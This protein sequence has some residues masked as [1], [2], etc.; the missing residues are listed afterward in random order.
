MFY[1]GRAIPEWRGSL[2]IAALRGSHVIR[3]VIQNNKVVGEERLFADLH[4]RFRHVVQG[5]DQAIY[6]IIDDKDGKIFRISK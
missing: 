3:L 1:T 6:A 2:F 4:K 5:P